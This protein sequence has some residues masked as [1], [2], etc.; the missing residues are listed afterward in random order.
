MSE[1]KKCFL[2]D[3][4]CEIHSDSK[5]HTIKGYRCKYCGMY[6]LDDFLPNLSPHLNETENKFKMACISK[7]R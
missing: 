1:D 7:T 4:E 6:S 2:C 3:S 5:W